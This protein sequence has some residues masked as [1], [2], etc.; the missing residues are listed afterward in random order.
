[1]GLLAYAGRSPGGGPSAG[2]PAPGFTLPSTH[3]GSVALSDLRGRAVLLYFSEGVGCDPCFSQ[4]VELERNADL[5]AD[6]GLTVLPVVVNPAAGVRRE[7]A[8][9]GIR[10]PFLIDADRSV[11]AAYGVLGQGMHPDLPGHTFVLVDEEGRIRREVTYPS[12]FVETEA[13]LDDLGLAR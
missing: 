10:T 4:M 6:A 5:L 1:M 2:D 11:S 12:M 9:F 8:R 3:G 7:L 13:L